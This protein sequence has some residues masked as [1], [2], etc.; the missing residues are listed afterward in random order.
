MYYPQ[1]NVVYIAINKTGSSS[2]AAALNEALYEPD[3]PALWQKLPYH[4]TRQVHEELTHAPASF[5]L[6][7]LGAEK[8]ARSLVITQVRNPWDRMVSLFIFRCRAPKNVER[9]RRER[10][11]FIENGLLEPSGNPGREL[12]SAFLLALKS[13]AQIPSPQWNRISRE[14]NLPDK[15]KEFINQ[16]DGLTDQ[17]NNILV[18]EIMRFECLSADWSRARDRLER[19]T[20]RDVGALPHLNKSKRDDYK[21]YYDE[22]TH[23]VVRQ[24]FSRDIEYF[25]YSF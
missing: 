13:G 1:A 9:W 22:H 6:S 4:K 25:N 23:E 5:Y 16:L 24:L 20:G 11:W 21:R 14:Y 17:K 2:V 8:L 3:V 12:F 10:L 18:D 15:E 19:H 7:A